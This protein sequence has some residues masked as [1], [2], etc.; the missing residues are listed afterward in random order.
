MAL[1]SAEV[2]DSDGLLATYYAA[3]SGDKCPAASN[4]ML[5]IKNAD[6]ASTV[7]TLT[8]PKVVGGLA[9][10]DQAITIAAGTEQFAG[11]FPAMTYGD[12]DDEVAMAWSNL[13][14]VTFAVLAI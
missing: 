12:A 3:A 6:A 13:T 7:L 8:T 14:S 2:I 5:H 4:V 1:R 11:P 9:V 10:A